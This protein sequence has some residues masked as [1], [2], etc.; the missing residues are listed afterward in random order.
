VSPAAR[1]W[2]GSFRKD[3][4]EEDAHAAAAGGNLGVTVDGVDDVQGPLL[5]DACLGIPALVQ[6]DADPDGTFDVLGWVEY[7]AD[8]VE[9]TTLIGGQGRGERAPGLYVRAAGQT[10]GAG[11]DRRFVPIRL[12]RLRVHFW[13]ITPHDPLW[14]RLQLGRNQVWLHRQSVRALARFLAVAID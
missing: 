4:T 12:A 11:V 2:P 6:V 8:A 13:H 5:D 3:A 9:L 1:K 10:A 14:Q 7:Q